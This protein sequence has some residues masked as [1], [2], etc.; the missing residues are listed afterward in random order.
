MFDQRIERDEFFSSSRRV[1]RVQLKFAFRIFVNS[2]VNDFIQ[3]FY[4]KSE[5]SRSSSRVAN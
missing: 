3:T 1:G 4:G 5:I 2:E